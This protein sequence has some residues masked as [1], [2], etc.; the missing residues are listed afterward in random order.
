MTRR[1]YPIIPDRTPRPMSPT[2]RRV[3]AAAFV[4]GAL[5]FGIVA[6]TYDALPMGVIV[7]IILLAAV[8]AA[9]GWMVGR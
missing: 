7:L 4:P 3:R 8:C 1:R 9:A 5:A 6:M 2:A